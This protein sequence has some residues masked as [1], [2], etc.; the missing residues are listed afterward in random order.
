MY[1]SVAL[2]GDETRTKSATL[3]TIYLYVKCRLRVPGLSAPLQWSPISLSMPDC[4]GAARITM[5]GGRDND[6]TELSLS[7][8]SSFFQIHNVSVVKLY[9]STRFVTCL[10]PG[11]AF[12][13][14]VALL[15]A[16]SFDFCRMGMRSHSSSQ[17]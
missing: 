12:G 7:P 10:N 17:R 8:S 11:L 6:E 4:P 13:F 16:K 5:G 1:Q 2:S 3:A 14:A 15:N 9:R